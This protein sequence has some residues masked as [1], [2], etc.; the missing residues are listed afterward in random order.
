MRK[1]SIPQ[2]IDN[3]EKY[4]YLTFLED[5]NLFEIENNYWK[6]TLFK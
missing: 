4:G 3:T 5:K 2:Y 6:S 1:Y